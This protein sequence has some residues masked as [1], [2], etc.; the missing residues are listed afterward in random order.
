MKQLGPQDALSKDPGHP[1]FVFEKNSEGGKLQQRLILWKQ[2]F[3]DSTKA[4]THPAD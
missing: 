1:F 2:L 4:R 3:A